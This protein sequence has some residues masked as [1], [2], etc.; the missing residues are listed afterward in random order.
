MQTA[1][2]ILIVEDDV[3]VRMVAAAALED[4]GYRVIEAD[5]AAEALELLAAEESVSVLFTDINMP[6]MD[7]I[8]LARLASERR[9]GLTVVLTSGYEQPSP[10]ELPA[11]GRFLPKPYLP[12]EMMAV[13][14]SIAA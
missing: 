2:P 11:R 13:I 12:E 9:P 3:L 7:G 10:D 8:Q 1:A 14:T 6:G 4:A 5:C